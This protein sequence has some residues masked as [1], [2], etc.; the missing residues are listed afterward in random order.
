M[1]IS[2]FSSINLYESICTKKMTKQLLAQTTLT[3]HVGVKANQ[4]DGLASQT[5]R[6]AVKYTD[7]LDRPA[8]QT[9]QMDQQSGFFR[10]PVSCRGFFMLTCLPI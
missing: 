4:F 1:I 5:S 3:K 6:K 2:Q 9:G 8:R 7:K 10:K